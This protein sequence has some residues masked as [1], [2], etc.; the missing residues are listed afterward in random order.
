MYGIVHSGRG[1]GGAVNYILDSGGLNNKIIQVLSGEGIPL[2][3]DEYGRTE[4]DPKLISQSFRA[5]ANLRPGITKPVRHLVLTCKDEDK[6]KLS[7]EAWVDIAR[8]YMNR[9]GIVNTQ[10]LIVAHKEKNNPHIHILYNRINNEGTPIAEGNF[11]KRNVEVCKAITV[12]RGLTWGNCKALSQSQSNRPR[13]R[14]Q[15]Y[16]ARVVTEELYYSSSMNDLVRRL[17]SKG[18]SVSLNKHENGRIGISFSTVADNGQQYH[19]SGSSLGRYLTFPKIQYILANKES[20]EAALRDAEKMLDKASSIP[21]INGKLVS[22]LEQCIITARFNKDTALRLFPLKQ[23]KAMSTVISTGATLRK[24]IRVVI[25]LSPPVTHASTTGGGKA[26]PSEQEQ[27]EEAQEK[28]SEGAA[29]AL[30]V[31]FKDKRFVE[32]LV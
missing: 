14:V 11:K 30:H 8:D 20:F 4:F 15:Y 16:T 22:R 24:M 3:I 10:Y 21:G 13:E 28:W 19:F 12:E 26:T 7:A 29:G 25:I 5:Q 27:R 2:P 23:A 18:I 1:F 6:K 17:D 9:M 31:D 32:R